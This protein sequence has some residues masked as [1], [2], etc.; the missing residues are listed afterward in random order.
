MYQGVITM[1]HI[2]LTI[3]VTKLRTKAEADD[4]AEAILEHLAETFN[5]DGSLKLDKASFST[6]KH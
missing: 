2:T 6:D 1:Y 5:D 4:M 3:P